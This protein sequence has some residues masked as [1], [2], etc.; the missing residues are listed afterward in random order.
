MAIITGAAV[1]TRVV[2]ALAQHTDLRRVLGN[3]GR[4]APRAEVPLL[5]NRIKPMLARR[6][7]FCCY[8]PAARR[9]VHAM[10]FQRAPN[11]PTCWFCSRTSLN[12][13]LISRPQGIEPHRSAVATCE[14]RQVNRVTPDSVLITAV[15]GSEGLRR[16]SIE[17]AVERMVCGHRLTMKIRKLSQRHSIRNAFTQLT[18][19]PVLDALKNERAQDLL[20]RQSSATT[21]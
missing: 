17:V 3:A 21:P 10:R 7:R 6:P 12:W 5:S 4:L 9:A 13:L 20:R 15:D 8:R 14:C 16:Q 18:V 1:L 19:I 11:L 2:D